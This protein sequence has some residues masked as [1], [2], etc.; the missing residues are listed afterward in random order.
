VL[1]NAWSAEV[2]QYANG[3]GDKFP[4]GTVSVDHT[5]LGQIQGKQISTL[6]PQGGHVLCVTGPQRSS[7]AVERLEGL[8]AAVRNDVTVYET[9]AGG[10]TESDGAAAFNSWYGLFKTRT[11]TIDVI[12]AQSDELAIGARNACEAVTNP[13]HRALL[14]KARFLGV[15]ACPAFGRRLV[16]EGK[17]TAS[18]TMPANTAEAIRALRRFWESGQPLPL[19]AHTEPEAYPPNSAR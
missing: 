9:G 4:F 1:L 3:W 11:F 8:K 14:L 15:D 6:L 13:A 18:V 10:W 17:L 2:Q 7:A 19:K 16:D 5:R 12:A